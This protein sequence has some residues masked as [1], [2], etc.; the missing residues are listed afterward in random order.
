MILDR[1]IEM[2][3]CRFQIYA[4]DIQNKFLLMVTTLVGLL[5]H[6]LELKGLLG[7]INSLGFDVLKLMI[8]SHPSKANK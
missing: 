6:K 3:K 2:M 5:S 4:V 1:M 8:I 7:V